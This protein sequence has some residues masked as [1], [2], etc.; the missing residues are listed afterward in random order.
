[1]YPLSLHSRGNCFCSWHFR[2]L[3]GI[4]IPPLDLRLGQTKTKTFKTKNSERR[5]RGYGI[6]PSNSTNLY[7]DYDRV[8]KCTK[9]CVMNLKISCSLFHFLF[10]FFIIFCCFQGE[11]PFF[12]RRQVR[13]I[14]HQRYDIRRSPRQR[15]LRYFVVLS[16]RANTVWLSCI[17]RKTP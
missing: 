14:S 11:K 15:F 7:I 3:W 2:F 16:F 1:M 5:I 10:C 4:L 17:S 9:F 8:R 13:F 12:L 6:Q